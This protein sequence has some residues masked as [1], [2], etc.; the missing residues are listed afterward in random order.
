MISEKPDEFVWPTPSPPSAAVGESICRTCTKDLVPRKP[1]SSQRRVLT[2]IVVSGSLFALLLTLGWQRHPPK[3]A[4]L[5]ALLGALVWGIIQASLLFLGHG[6]PPG[7]RGARGLRLAAVL[8]IPAIFVAH[9]TITSGSVLPFHDFLVFPRSLRS[10]AVCGVHSLLFGVGASAVLFLLWRRTD[11]FNPRLTG[12]L[13]G[14]AGGLVGA[15][16]LDMVCTNDEAWHLWLGH[17]AT[18]LAFA[19]GGWFAGRWWISP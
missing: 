1:P 7:R 11:P 8:A 4:V 9:L 13:T 5:L 14:L 6:R 3:D 12:A 16:A 17:G 10:A 19:V 2:S 15:V 18:L